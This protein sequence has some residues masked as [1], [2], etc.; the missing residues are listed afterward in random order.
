M[1]TEQYLRIW[2]AIKQI[3][4]I[5]L[6]IFADH[7]KHVSVLLWFFNDANLMSGLYFEIMSLK[8]VRK[9]L[10]IINDTL[11]TVRFAGDIY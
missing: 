11:L 6:H 7:L 9:R 8:V 10:I 5:L 3:L 4:S 1:H 2:T